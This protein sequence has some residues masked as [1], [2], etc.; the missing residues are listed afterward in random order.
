MPPVSAS[1]PFRGYGARVPEVVTYELT[2]PDTAAGGKERPKDGLVGPSH[3]DM[4]E[5]SSPG[6]IPAASA[7]RQ[8]TDTVVSVAAGRAP[9]NPV[10]GGARDPASAIGPA[11]AAEADVA[12][13][14]GAAI[15]EQAVGVP[16]AA[17]QATGGVGAVPVPEAEAR[18]SVA[19]GVK[20]PVQAPVSVSTTAEGSSVSLP[21]IRKAPDRSSSEIV[22]VLFLGDIMAH[23]Q[24]IKNAKTKDGYDFTR[25]FARIKPFLR[26]AMVVGNL[27][28]TFSG[29]KRKFTG[30]PA[31]NTPDELA[32]ALV[33]LGVHVVT[34]ANNHILDRGVSGVER[35]LEVLDDAGI[36][37]TGV[38]DRDIAPGQ[39]LL[40]EYGGL[41]WAFVNFTYGSNQPLSKKNEREIGINVISEEAVKESL[42]AA[43]ELGPDVTVALFHWG[44]E[45]QLKPSAA[46]VKTAELAAAE[47][48]DLVI[49]T[50]P[51]V[52]QPVTM[53]PTDKGRTL[54]AYSLGNFIANQVTAPRERGMVLAAEFEK[55]E[56]G[57]ARLV[58]ASIAP[59]LMTTICQRKGSG[60]SLELLYGGAAPPADDP[61][62]L[63]A[64]AE[65]GLP[66]QL[67]E[68]G[69]PV[70]SLLLYDDPA[71]GVLA[72]TASAS[73]SVSDAGGTVIP[74]DGETLAVAG[75]NGPDAGGP[76]KDGTGKP[77]GGGSPDGAEGIG[78]P[79]P[80]LSGR[81][82][83]KALR[84]GERIM[85][86]IGAEA[87]VDEYGYYTVWDVSAPDE[88]PEGSRKSPS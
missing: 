27:E 46:Q 67:D 8:A 17:V 81:D 55:I 42:R 12:P 22:R 68:D 32:E 57:G 19:A 13:A 41:R 9:G 60:C 20:A 29:A 64:A 86:Y 52:L 26:K 38:S 11:G 37:W 3:E 30:Y 15:P 65:P 49:G 34:L 69:V 77:A 51:H 40:V 72:M 56:G 78:N 36:L 39:P 87:E 53:L 61:E 4:A 35:T 45:Y 14:G 82:A 66:P 58:R 79:I 5:P 6:G 54:V 62:P 43:R 63:V 21:A 23:G 25:Q 73:D 44:N 85:E 50:H 10:E 71:E 28:T 47:G 84:A 80:E 24:Q 33:D 88:L 7:A 1:A 16:G 59:L 70:H 18:K 74:S 83:D 31:F 48:A 75:G 76:G 2:L